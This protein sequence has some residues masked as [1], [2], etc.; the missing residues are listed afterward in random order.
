MIIHLG[1]SDVALAA[2][3]V[4]MDVVMSVWLRLG[5]HKQLLVASVRMVVQLTLVGMVLVLVFRATSPWATVAAGGVMV[6]AAIRE[7]AARP[8]GRLAGGGNYWIAGITVSVASASAVLLVLLTAIRPEPWYDPR[9]AISVLGIILGT[10]LNSAS[11]ALDA[12]LDAART[13][14]A[15]IE[16]RLALGDT[17]AEAMSDHVSAAVRRSLI[18]VINQ[19]A[20]AGVITLP[21]IMTGQLLAGVAPLEAAKYQILLLFLLAGAGGLASLGTAWLATRYLCDDR[22]RL[23]LDRLS[24]PR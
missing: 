12:I 21:G 16:A 19:M 14:R 18:P 11:L 13:G 15:A 9:Y 6:L 8:P 22:D 7:V 24:G 2:L 4:C 3:L 17:F 5:I 23:R 20:A 10:V 1:I